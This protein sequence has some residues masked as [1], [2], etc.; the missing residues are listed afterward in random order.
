M[1]KSV[2]KNFLAVLLIFV[3]MS[4]PCFAA[5]QY[6]VSYKKALIK[7]SG[8]SEY[9]LKNMN[10]I[11]G[12]QELEIVIKE[13]ND[14]PYK[15]WSDKNE[16]S[17]ELGLSELTYRAGLHSHTTASDGKA[18]PVQALDQAAEYANK[19]KAKNPNEKYPM[20]VA[21]TDHY[22]TE[23]CQQ[24]ID[25]IQKNPE[26]YKNIKVLLGMETTALTEYPSDDERGTRVHVLLWGID[27]YSPKM[28][29]MNF[30]PFEK[31]VKEAQ[32]LDYGVVGLA[33]PLRYYE[34]KYRDNPEITKKLITEYYDN[35]LSMKK[36][37]F[38]FA[39]A[40]YQ[41]YRFK[42]SDDLYDYVIN[43][44]DRCGFYKTG[45]QDSHGYTI[46]H[47]NDVKK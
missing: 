40:Y 21:I 35:Y 31:L 28:T 20:I 2:F 39:E 27:P 38:L 11:I 7:S 5:N 23:G 22:N 44:S 17:D 37:K 18:T 30:L 9:T 36:N 29:Q 47:N 24:A 19:V 3:G 41:P 32:K 33:H 34:E 14:K 42:I 6:D 12:E 10:S 43:E 1:N 26:K 45:S 15:Y 4:A 25:A 46:F 13:Y 8:H 16:F